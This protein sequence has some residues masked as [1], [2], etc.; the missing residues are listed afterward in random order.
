[1][2]KENGTGGVLNA[3][4][5]GAPV[6]KAS[7]GGVL[8]TLGYSMWV[9]RLAVLFLCVSLAGNAVL[10]WLLWVRSSALP[11]V[12]V[13]DDSG[14]RSALVA[15]YAV[16][17]ELVF[18]FVSYVIPRLYLVTDGRQSGLDSVKNLV[19]DRILEQERRAFSRLSSQVASSK[20]SWQAQPVRLLVG[21]P[22][23]RAFA[24]SERL[25]MVRGMVEGRTIV[26]TNTLNRSESVRWDVTLEIIAPSEVNLWGLRLVGL[27]ARGLDEQ[28]LD[29]TNWG[30]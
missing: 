19:D 26:I 9:T 5:P 6:M 7:R 13:Q 25:G 22:D 11:W 28:Q 8:Y 21:T 27:E 18:A 30:Y 29:L 20:L 17:P 3:D 24:I 15:R 14:R 4:S 1:M 23:K 12:V 2:A 16:T 10:F